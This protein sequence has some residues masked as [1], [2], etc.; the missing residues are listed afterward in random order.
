MSFVAPP[1]SAAWLHR[2]ARTGFEV[3]YC[4]AA[5]DGHVLTGCTTAVED[6]E[7]W[8][9]SYEIEVSA[10]WKTRSALIRGRSGSVSRTVVLDADGSG[11]WRIDGVAAPTLNGCLDVDLESSAL[12]NALPVH[13][14]GLAIGERAAA[15]AAYVHAADLTV[16]RLEQDYVRIADQDTH[17]RYEYAAPS[18]GFGA[19]LIYDAAGLVLDYPGIAVRAR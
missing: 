7:P 4:A 8:I 19:R 6:G 5:A 2:D 12:T 18:F 1:T 15:P 3:V 16:H 13:R 9:V 10:D 11:H 14:L 17:Q